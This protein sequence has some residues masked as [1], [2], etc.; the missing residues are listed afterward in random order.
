MAYTAT[1]KVSAD[2]IAPEYRLNDN[3]VIVRSNSPNEYYATLKLF[4]CS[5]NYNTPEAAVCGLL[6]DNG[7]RNI[8]L[9]KVEEK[10]EMKNENYVIATDDGSILCRGYN[11]YKDAY[12]FTDISTEAQY[13][14]FGTAQEAGKFLGEMV[15]SNPDEKYR[16]S[17]V[18]KES[19][20][21]RWRLEHVSNVTRSANKQGLTQ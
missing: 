7:C 14:R 2:H 4:G 6:A 10:A 5:K 19:E 20:A 15:R 11:L 1:F 8:T 18:C 3:T 17:F 9:H 13:M 21:F 12:R 16:G